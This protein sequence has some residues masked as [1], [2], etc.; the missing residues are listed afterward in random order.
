MAQ[1]RPNFLF[2]MA[3]QLSALALPAYGHKVVKAPH[4]DSLAHGG[5]VFDN[6]YCN[7]PICAPARFA[8]L[9]GQ[10]T[11]R[12]GAFDNAAEFASSVPTL[13][14]YLRSLGYQTCLS[15]K[16]HFIGPDQL[17]G[18]EERL[19]TDI[20]PADFAWTPDWSHKGLPRSAVSARGVVEA[21]LCQRNLQI[22]FD[23][24]VHYHGVQ[25][26]YDLARARDDRPFMLTV[27]Y[28]H[29][30]NPFIIT[31]DYWDRYRDD[32]IDLPATPPIPYAQRDPHSKRHYWLTRMDEY[33][34]TEARVRTARHAYYGMTSY[35]DDKVGDLMR[36]LDETGLAANTVVV[37]TADH[38]EMLGERGMW[39]KMCFFEPAMRVPL[40]VRMPAGRA[41]ASRIAHNVSH[42]D[43]LPTFLDLATDGH[44]PTMV[45]A[46]DGHSLAP[47]LDGDGREWSHDVYAEYTADGS[48]APCFMIRSGPHKYIWSAP[49]GAQLFDLA[50]D[51]RELDDLAG[52]PAAAAVEVQMQRKLHAQWDVAAIEKA[53]LASQRRR[54]FLKPFAGSGA[55]S[56]EY[57]PFKDASQQY[58]RG[59]SATV[60]K[61]LSRFPYVDPLP[62]DHPRDDK[63]ADAAA[64]R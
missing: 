32:E 62:P 55:P 21:G 50:A 42:V 28:T 15:G 40:I 39:Y 8:T 48:I 24:D 6:A 22:D 52:T 46:V 41:G 53:V 14:H 10:L 17:H 34:M 27:S 2:I 19:T 1:Q 29:P 37:L 63:A 59:H 11:S 64:G 35:V 49:D 13:L 57:Q 4:I 36:V 23:E 38:G 31:Q 25:K 58:V 43:L 18:Y 12:I 5:T 26:L 56:W 16:M 51:P 60:A 44:P 33:D 54:L 45:E 47:L 3:D 9:S 61:G 30:H 20:Y 7:F